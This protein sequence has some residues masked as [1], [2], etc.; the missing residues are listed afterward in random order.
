MDTAHSYVTDTCQYLH[1]KWSS[2]KAA[3]G[4]VVLVVKLHSINQGAAAGMDDISV[5]DF[6]RMMDDL[7]R[8]KFQAITALQLA[9][10]LESNA[11]IPFRSVALI[12]D[13]RHTAENF[14]DRFRRYWDAWGWPII[15][16]WDARASS[17]QTVWAQQSALEEEGWVDHEAYG[18]SITIS[19]NKPNANQLTE[20]MQQSIDIFEQR[21][22]KRP[23]AIIWPAGLDR[24]VIGSARDLGFR[25]GFTFNA[26]GP[27]MYN[28]IPLADA[29]DPRRPSYLAD[30]PLGDPQMTLPRYWPNQVRGVLDAVR[31]IGQEAAAF[32]DQN[33]A[34]ELEYYD[35]VCAAKDGPLS[36]P[37]PSHAE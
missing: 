19:G 24:D 4:T 5:P 2:Q 20:Q 7:D 6:Q 31:L 28:W 11:K 36:P 14:N 32:A 15:N 33:K 27:L 12:Q 37:D 26:R 34:T 3:P 8:Q 22:G 30:G 16:A 17:S 35:I 18:P 25:L 29:A 21:F 9:D 10:F 23:V 1:D 13:G